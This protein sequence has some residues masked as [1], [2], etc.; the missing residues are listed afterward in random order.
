MSDFVIHTFPGSPFARAVMATVLEKG[1]SFRLSPLALGAHKAEPHI[2]RHPFGK[3]PV[4]EHGGFL[5][6][7]TQAILRYL[8]RVLP[9]PSLTP[10]DP[11]AAAR[12]DQVM[13]INDCYLFNGVANVIVFQRVI[14]PAL[15][16]LAPDEAAIEAAMP[17]AH[18]VF[19]ELAGLLGEKSYFAGERVSLADL[20]VAPQL[21]FFTETPEWATLTAKHPNLKAWLARMNARPSMQATTW[22]RVNELAKAA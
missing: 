19:D 20:A 8:D 1:A 3:M 14:G 17:N 22:P 18:V 11:K 4:L 2:S 9:T 10:A 6:Y 21:D 7:E 15:M 5:L 13:N 16:G 12:M